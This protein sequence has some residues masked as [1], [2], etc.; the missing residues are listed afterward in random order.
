MVDEGRTPRG[1]RG[2][3]LDK[4]DAMVLGTTSH[5]AWGAWIETLV[6]D[7]TEW[8]L[9]GRTPRGVRGLKRLLA[10]GLEGSL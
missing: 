4:V 5:P 6:E 2:L 1:V 8:S 7:N 10:R 3:K 9:L